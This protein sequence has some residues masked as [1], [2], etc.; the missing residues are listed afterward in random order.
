MAARFPISPEKESALLNRM[1]KLGI[2]ES[3]LEESFM[4]SGGKGGQNVNKVSTAVRLF[5][6]PSGTEVK[7]SIHRTQGL[8]RYKARI[9][10]CEKL[11]EEARLASK[12]EDP[13]HAKI[14]KAKADRARK[15]KRKAQ[16][17]SSSGLKREFVP[18][19]DWE[20][21][22]GNDWIREEGEIP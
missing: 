22:Y 3:D 7:C 21:E 12:I 17:K 2:Q 4:R 19:E 6:K 15:A 11:E 16:A 8:N 1:S 9:L 13:E 20:E 5:H 18:E 10:L 14:R